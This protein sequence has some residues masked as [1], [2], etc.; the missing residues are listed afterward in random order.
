M[1]LPL[2]T[3]YPCLERESLKRIPR[4]DGTTVRTVV[5]YTQYTDVFTLTPMHELYS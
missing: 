3:K 5:L 1:L 4:S 2:P